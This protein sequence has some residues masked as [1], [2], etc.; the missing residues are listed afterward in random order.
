MPETGK[1]GSAHFFNV[2]GQSRRR[3]QGSGIRL[4]AGTLVCTPG[5]PFITTN[6]IEIRARRK[7]AIPKAGV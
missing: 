4:T 7:T 2:E 5:G 3:D 6:P 1:L